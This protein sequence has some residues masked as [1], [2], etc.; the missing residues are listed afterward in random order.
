MMLSANPP[1]YFATLYRWLVIRDQLDMPS[2]PLR[3]L[4]VG[5]H[6]SFILRQL[7]TDIRIGVDLEPHPLPDKELVLMRASAQQLPFLQESFECILAFDILEHIEN[8]RTA[9]QEILRVLAP[10]GTLWFSTPS[11][12]MRMYPWFFTDYTN[13]KFGHMRNGYTPEQIQALLPDAQNW[14]VEC[15]YW[16]EPAF[17]LLFSTLYVLAIGMPRL[18]N[19]IVTYCYHIDRRFANGTAG[20]I[21]GAIRTR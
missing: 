9:L 3:I 12:G 19:W 8:D 14:Q 10:N 4:D 2:H 1:L 21:F 13:K 18:A 17:R 11:I 5:C 6:D 16:N 15:F 20:H 7:S